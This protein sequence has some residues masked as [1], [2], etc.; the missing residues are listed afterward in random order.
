M[1]HVI[2]IGEWFISKNIEDTIKTYAL[3]SCVAVTAYSKSG[4]VAGMIHIALP[5][6]KNFMETN[7][8]KR[9]YF[10][11]SGIPFLINQMEQKFDCKRSELKICL[12]GGAIS[13][14]EN[15]VFKIGQKNLEM[16]QQT[17]GEMGLKCYKSDVGG[18]ASRT[19]DI[20]VISGEVRVVYG[21]INI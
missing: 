19:I 3:A 4:H 9:G 6:K 13:K 20:N 15:D 8:E 7:S 17:L 16:I 10:A 21:E 14:K 1:E 18:V 5:E 11:K 12:Y 2:G